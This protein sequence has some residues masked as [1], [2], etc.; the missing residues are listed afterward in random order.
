M[1]TLIDQIQKSNAWQEIHAQPH[2]WRSWSNDFSAKAYRSWIA[3]LGISEVWFCGAGTSAYIG[4][5]IAAG[6][7]NAGGIK[8]QS[9]AST[10]LVA[11]ARYY[12]QNPPNDLLIVNFGRSGNSSETVETLSAIEVLVP[13]LPTPNI[14][15]NS[16]SALAKSFR[17]RSILLADAC[18][19]A[20]FAMTSNF[21]TMLLEGLSI[22]DTDADARTSIGQL[23]EHAENMLPLLTDQILESEISSR[24]VFVGYGPIAFATGE[25]ALKVMELT[26]GKIPTLWDSTPGFR[27]GPKSYISGGTSI[28]VLRSA[29]Y[30]AI[31]Y[32]VDV[33]EELRVQFPEATT[34]TLGEDEKFSTKIIESS[35]LDSVLP[36]K[37]A[38]L[39]S[40]VWSDRL[41]LNVDDPSLRQSTLTR[42]VSGVQLHPLEPVK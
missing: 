37:P 21:S 15:G 41:D 42:V 22:F 34:I 9:I 18:H 12:L 23:A 27:H 40:V 3:Q 39:A 5:I 20:G 25:S 36:V 29:K 6:L 28:Y 17:G 8:F 16:N 35:A 14:T 30:P 10:D 33:V 19:G 13:S 4:H 24:A 38:Q 1:S 32:E 26:T 31:K 11:C 2:I 7:P